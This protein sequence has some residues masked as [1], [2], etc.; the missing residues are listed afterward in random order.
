LKG[1]IIGFFFYFSAKHY[2][3]VGILSVMLAG[4]IF[5]DFSCFSYRMF[6]LGYLQVSLLK[7][8]LGLWLIIVP[9]VTIFGVMCN[10]MVHTLLH[11]NLYIIKLF[12]NGSLFTLFFMA[13]ILLVDKGLRLTT[14]SFVKNYSSKIRFKK[15]LIAI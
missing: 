9:V 14:V 4:N 11:I 5:V 6:K 12:I 2:G 3:I 10:Y 13:V 7:N 1:S 8:I 15:K